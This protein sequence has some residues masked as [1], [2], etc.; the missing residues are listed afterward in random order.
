MAATGR[1]KVSFRGSLETRE[2]VWFFILI[3]PW[4]AGY[5][6]FTLGPMIASAVLGFTL[7][8]PV[9]WPPRWIGLGNYEFMLQDKL[10]WQS[11]KVTAYF[12]FL[13]VPLSVAMATVIAL[14][15]N[16]K[17]PAVSAWRT[18][19]YLPSI[20]AGVPVAI[21]WSWVFEPS[22]GLLNGTLYTLTGIQGPGWLVQPEWVI[23]SFVIM[24]LW[25]FGGFMLIY[26]AAIQG[27]PT[28]LFESA[29]IDGA[30]AF[31]KIQHITIPSITPVI[32]FNGIL[33]I[34]G[35]FQAFTGAFI[36]TSGGPQY[37]SYFMVYMIYNNAFRFVSSMGY[38]S[39]LSWVLFMILLVF[40]YL[41]FR[42]SRYW[43]F[44]ETEAVGGNGGN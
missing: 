32:F 26:L 22:F 40:T 12:T 23:P 19:Y 30:T 4:F 14:V 3:A 34:I 7:A 18:I 35:S 44:Y 28:Q 43:V 2:A 21:M 1:K 37:A 8:D 16:E 42:S 11:L 20:V 36:I 27:I 5:I 10:F 24:S 31:Q 17:L 41:A 6:L 25:G 29:E 33:A 38:A 9:I 13:S 15:L 39:A